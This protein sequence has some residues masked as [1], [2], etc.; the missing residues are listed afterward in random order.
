MAAQNVILTTNL[1]LDRLDD[2]APAELA[3]QLPQP[4]LRRQIVW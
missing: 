2:I 1:D 3:E 4:E